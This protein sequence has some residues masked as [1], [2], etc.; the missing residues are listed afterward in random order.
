MTA[1]PH[2][3][4]TLRHATAWVFTANGSLTRPV[5]LVG[6]AGVE[7]ADL[8][9]RADHPAY[10]LLSELKARG[11]DL[12]LLGLPA[13]GSMTGD[14]GTV[15]NAVAR[16]VAEQLGSHPLTVGGTGQGA[17]AA[18]YA[19]AGMEYQRIDHR[20]G[21]LFSHNGA[22]P[23]LE[24]EAE[25][26]RMGERPRVPRFLRLVDEGVTD[27]LTGEITEDAVTGAAAPST[28]P[29]LPEEYGSWL[30]DRLP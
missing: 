19:L 1:E 2:E 28:G 9:A 10:S 4:W 17:L 16:A 27:G 30:L 8:A 14:G 20:T 5:V 23:E 13:D 25:L 7:L 29:L 3:T 11:H 15:Q 18:R 21:V 26:S 12:V 6:D 22:A 24:D